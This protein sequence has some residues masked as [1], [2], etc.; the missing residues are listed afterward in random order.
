[1]TG[2]INSDNG[3]V[4]MLSKWR[5]FLE[6]V[7]C[8]GGGALY[9]LSLPPANLG[10]LAWVCLLPLLY[11]IIFSERSIL[12]AGL[13]GWVWGIG[14]AIFSYWFLREIE[15][16]VPFLL[17]PVMALWPSV[18][19][20][21][22]PTLWYYTVYPAN[23]DYLPCSQRKEILK[24]ISAW[25]LFL[26]SLEAAALFTLLE[27]S[28]SRLFVWND[29]SVTQWRYLP[30]IQIS[31]I[32]GSYGV[33][34]LVAYANTLFFSL[35]FRSGYKVLLA[36]LPLYIAVLFFGVWRLNF[37]NVTGNDTITFAP[38]LIQGNLS[39]R[40]HAD[41]ASARE[42]LDTYFSLS[43]TAAKTKPELIIW[44]ESA[45]PIA[46]RSNHPLAPEFRHRLHEFLNRYQIPMLLGVLDFEE[47][48]PGETKIP[49]LTNSAILF[50][51]TGMINAKYDKIH[52]VP[53][54]EYI[55]FRSFLPDFLIEYIDMGRDL[56]AG[57]NYD[58]IVVKPGLRAGVA[59][60]YEGVFGYLTREFAR[61][62]A[63]V[64]IVLSNDAWYPCS[65]EPEQH[66][67]N[68][69]MRAVETNLPMIR[70]GNNGGSGVVT[71]FGEY[72][73]GISQA[74][75]VRS[76]LLRGQGWG[77]VEIKVS[78][79]PESFFVTY[80]EWFIAL[81]GVLVFSQW[82]YIILRKIGFSRQIWKQLHASK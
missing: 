66:L 40:R 77:K 13:A 50:D 2:I 15:F 62:G 80:G 17:A 21:F 32:T 74:P 44:P 5:Y 56:S 11:T 35:H 24:N 69:T 72:T 12:R 70:C 30:L 22:I 81:L 73:Q 79:K 42:A 65:S 18:W 43:D 75:G 55:P 3:R 9:A 53:Y 57:N 51:S 29:L 46:L 39:Q 28:R 45:I 68:A 10:A 19:A 14:W 23:S 34:F 20:M 52:R 37:N 64:L 82:I 1:M 76:E 27:W 71:R 4:Y 67:A 54:G 61:R 31:V 78:R 6:L 48:N 59:I 41:S 7:F 26:F 47:R 36:V 60:C 16:A 49:G 33:G 8:F 38:M 58:P 63:N 25:R